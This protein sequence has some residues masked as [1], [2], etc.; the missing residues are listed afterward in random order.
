MSQ[1]DTQ[2]DKNPE[3][4]QLFKQKTLCIF[5]QSFDRLRH[6]EIRKGQ[7]GTNVLSSMLRKEIKAV[8]QTKAGRN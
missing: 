3:I 7:Q 4:F 2:N 1:I 6:L 8:F 5:P